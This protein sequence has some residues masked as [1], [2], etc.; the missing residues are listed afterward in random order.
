MV[1]T[2]GRERVTQVLGIVVLIGFLA[3]FVVFS[4]PSVVGAE[5]SYVVVSGS[6][7]PTIGVGGTVIVDEVPPAAIEEGDI[8]TFRRG[9]SAKI[10]EGMAGEYLVTHRVVDIVPGEKG[11]M[12]RTK[13]DANED[14]DAQL[15]PPDALVGRVMFSIPYIGH[16]IAFAGTRLGFISLVAIPLGL[17]VLG[18]LYDFT[19]AILNRRSETEQRNK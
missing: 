13:G 2:P 1:S 19:R 17:L 11:P 14:P 9:G 16:V 7:A 5:Y 8:I 15:V 10:R 12:F 3:P 18:E 6:M 4:V